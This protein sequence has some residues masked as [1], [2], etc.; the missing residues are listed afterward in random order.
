MKIKVREGLEIGDGCPA[1]IIAE[2]GSNWSSLDDC[3]TSIRAA[4]ACG[5]DAVKFQLFTNEAL[6]GPIGSMLKFDVK[7]V[8]PIEWLP[9]LADEAK[10]CGIEFMCS[11]FSPELIDAV[12]PHVAIHK[13]ASAEMTH[14]RMLERL[15][16]IGKPVILSTGAS[17]Q[18]DIEEALRILGQT[19]VIPLYCV[20]AY[21]AREVNLD[22]LAA[23]RSLTGLCGYSDHTTD[24]L[25]I[26]RAAVERGA[27]VIEKHVNFV[28]ARGPDA[29]HSLDAREFGLM[30]RS[31]RGDLSPSSGPR[32][33][34]RPMLVRHNRRLIATRAI[35]AGET[36]REGDNFGIYRSLRD[37]TEALSPFAID[38]VNGKTARV[39]IEAGHGIHPGSY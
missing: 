23:L 29:P 10:R 20:A 31:I 16:E 22:S 9:N 12:D 7:G 32:A 39:R 19:P 36:F 35:E 27:C 17:G 21:P 2:V 6:Y 24:V 1:F 25:V 11:A 14:K 15:A 8:L 26:P 3:L 13:V 38:E 30:V 5:A 28:Q 34:E 4:K 33:E 18:A 37:E